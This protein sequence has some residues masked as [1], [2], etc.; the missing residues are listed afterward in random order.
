MSESPAI[1]AA[2]D[3]M[4]EPDFALQ[5][6]PPSRVEE[7]ITEFG[8]LTD[9]HMEAARA[10]QASGATLGIKAPELKAIRYSHHR[11]AQCLAMGMTETQA[12]AACNITMGRIWV[13]KNSP[14][15]AELVA[16]YKEGIDAEFADFVTSAK[17]IGL[18][19]LGR[20]REVLDENPEQFTITQLIEAIKIIA[21]RSG[22]APVNRS[23][24]VSANVDLATRLAAARARVIPSGG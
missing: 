14:A 23:V 2:L 5:R 11:L 22:N 8:P 1:A 7:V 9:E 18:D 15:F 12:A 3:S 16:H 19:L 17:M 13:L 20:L 4:P 10:H 24:S 21:D 6:R